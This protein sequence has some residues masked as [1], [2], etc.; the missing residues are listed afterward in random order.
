M[1]LIARF[2]LW[3]WGWKIVGEMPKGVK[4]SLII[5]A[6]H[7]S[8]MDFIIGKL[9]FWVLKLKPFVVIK[10]EAFVFLVGILLR[11][12]GGVPIDRNNSRNIV[13][14]TTDLFRERDTCHVLITPEGTRNLNNN[15]KRGFYY[16]AQ[17][18]QVPIV[19]GYLDY[20]AKKGGLGPLI[21]PS[22]NFEED[23]KKIEEF[24]KN[25]K[26]CFPEKFNISYVDS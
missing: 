16:I 1:R 3:L 8:N 5:M 19:L 10:K 20:G 7:T 18:S 2:V 4:K 11:A 24:Y 9:G 13:K 14:F 21:Y 22:G 6:P 23:L 17:K 15:W 26:A 25:K 12:L